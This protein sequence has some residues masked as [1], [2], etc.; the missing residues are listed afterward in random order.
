MDTEEALIRACCENPEEVDP[1]LRLADWLLENGQ[2]ER[3]EFVKET[4]KWKWSEPDD[5]WET[6]RRK[7]DFGLLG[8][9]AAV[10]WKEIEHFSV[11]PQE[12]WETII[13]HRDRVLSTTH[14]TEHEAYYYVMNHFLT[15]GKIPREHPFSTH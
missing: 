14:P 5:N 2:E 10:I 13:Y 8:S 9:R 1:R 11:G 4:A 12:P 7:R 3:A 6:H 15:K